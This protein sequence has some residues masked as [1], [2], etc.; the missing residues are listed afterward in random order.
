MYYDGANWQWDKGDE[1]RLG[2]PGSVMFIEKNGEMIL[3][4]LYEYQGVKE[5][6]DV[7]CVKEN[8]PRKLW[9]IIKCS[10]LEHFHTSPEMCK[11]WREIAEDSIDAVIE[12][13]E[14]WNKKLSVRPFPEYLKEKML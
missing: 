13:Y 8:K 7:P 3:Q 5:W 9:E 2:D 4:Q 1:M 6:V 14:E 12:C 11:G 10:H